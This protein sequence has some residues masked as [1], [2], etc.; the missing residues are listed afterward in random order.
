MAATGK[1]VKDFSADEYAEWLR[2]Q[3]RRN[4]GEVNLVDEDRPMQ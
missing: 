1:E 3:C 4:D 2:G